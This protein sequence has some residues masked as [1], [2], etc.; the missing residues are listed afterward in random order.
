MDPATERPGT[1]RDS[2]LAALRERIVAYAA[3]RLSRDA[4]EDLAQ[5]VLLV[6]HEKYR[7]VAEPEE[8]FPLCMQILRYKMMAHYRKSARHGDEVPVEDY[9]LADDGDSPEDY[10]RKREVLMRLAAAV[11]KLGVECRKLMRLKL[12]GRTFAEIQTLLGARSINTIYTWDFRC[13]KHLLELM[14]GSWEARK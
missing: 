14:G 5:E 13:R 3:S 9:P 4:A 8:L 12:E 6:I 2:V 1:E 7:N 11:K 10:A